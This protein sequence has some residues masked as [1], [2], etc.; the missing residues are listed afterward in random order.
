MDDAEV[1][2][3][4]GGRIEQRRG[5]GRIARAVAPEIDPRVQRARREA[6]H[7]KARAE[8]LVMD[9]AAVDLDQGHLSASRFWHAASPGIGKAALARA[10]RRTVNA[11]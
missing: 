7:W 11:L 4:L 1:C 5:L 2:R 10:P 3:E 8:L 6:Q 9:L